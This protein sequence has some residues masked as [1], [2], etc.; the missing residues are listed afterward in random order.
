VAY[1]LPDGSAAPDSLT[2]DGGVRH[3]TPS[4]SYTAYMEETYPEGGMHWAG[5]VSSPYS[6][7]A[8]DQYAFVVSPEFPLPDTGKPFAGP[9]RY[10]VVGGYRSL[11]GDDDDGS[12][13]VDCRATDTTSCVASGVAEQDSLQPTRDLAVLPG[14]DAPVVEAGKHVAVPFDLRFAGSGGEGV[15]FSLASSRGTLSR[16]TLRPETDSDSAATVDV[17]VPP[18]TPAGVYEV[19]LTATALGEG[20][21]IIHKVRAGRLAVGGVEQRTGTMQFRVIDPPVPP[22]VD[23]PPPPPPPAP[24]VD[25]PPPSFPAPTP[26]DAPR[27]VRARLALSLGALPRRAY[28]GTEVSYRLVARNVSREPASRARVCMR[29]PGN[30]QFV[31]A[32]TRMRFAG[33]DLCFDRPR[34][35]AGA[36]VAERVVVHIDVDARAG[37]TRARATASA[38]NADLVRARARM[39]V[40]QRPC[41][42]QHV[43]VTG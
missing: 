8:G 15:A 42:A 27:A 30:V 4:A 21:T 14:G 38:A 5:Y 41:R 6:T 25:P 32:T 39:R 40:I 22:A 3:F 34:L 18:G 33:S 16:Q 31:R 43:P 19:S 24:A 1:R 35:A 13:P 36:E 9:F 17:A 10:Q 12:A 7:A 29:L 20:D 37:S 23:T 11:T 26:V 28:S 2:D